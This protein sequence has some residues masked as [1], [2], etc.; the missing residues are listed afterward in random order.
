MSELT[1]PSVSRGAAVPWPLRKLLVHPG[2]A[3]VFLRLPGGRVSAGLGAGPAQG[4]GGKDRGGRLSWKEE[5]QDLEVS[6][7]ERPAGGTQAIEVGP[8]GV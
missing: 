4:P 3:S 6:H 5:K 8:V 2:E 1:V 7:L